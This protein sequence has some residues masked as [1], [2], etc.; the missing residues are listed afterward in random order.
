ME[1]SAVCLR[2]PARMFCL[3]QQYISQRCF[4]Y[5][6]PSMYCKKQGDEQTARLPK[7]ST[8]SRGPTNLITMPRSSSSSAKQGS[9]SFKRECNKTKRFF[10]WSLEHSST[11]ASSLHPATTIHSRRKG[12]VHFENMLLKEKH[13]KLPLNM[14]LLEYSRASLCFPLWYFI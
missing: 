12:S 1:C 4:S 10:F 8:S 9:T 2:W 6:Q 7:H 11:T 14:S 5:M 13:T 3:S